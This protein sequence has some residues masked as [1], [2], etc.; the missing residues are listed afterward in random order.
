M[1]D[2]Q[3]PAWNPDHRPTGP[4]GAPPPPGTPSQP[5]GAPPQHTALLPQYGQQPHQGPAP[6]Y[7]QPPQYGNQPPQYGNQPLQYGNQAPVYGGQPPQGPHLGSLQPPGKRPKG[8]WLLIAAAAVVIALIGGAVVL[9]TSPGGDAA[10][11]GAPI[12]TATFTDGVSSPTV[13]PSTEPPSVTPSTPA[14]SYTTNPT[15]P[16]RRRTLKDIDQGIAVY[17]DVY[18]KPASGWR[19]L[20][21]SKYTVTLG[22]AS[23]GSL[24][25]MVVNPVGYPAAKAVPIIVRDLVALDKLAGVVKGPVKSLGPANSNIQSQAQMSY[26][27]R[28][29]QNG[30][31]VSVTARCTTMTGVESIHNVTVSVCVQ[32][33]PDVA[34]RA[35]RD[36]IGMLASVA[37]SI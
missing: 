1:S 25:T 13:S 24:L 8:P 31:S 15:P 6:Q 36:A 22:P 19:K 23:K 20:Y 34:D 17:D 10:D 12:P 7:D 27:G 29:R 16:E 4:Y 30:A 14:P 33:R 21:T 18:I 37:R 3:P 32:A 9:L 11:A 2:Q 26:T 28:I 5:Y 35:F